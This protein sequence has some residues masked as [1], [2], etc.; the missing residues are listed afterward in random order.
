VAGN[1]S[2]S[3]KTFMVGNVFYNNL[4]DDNKDLLSYHPARDCY[5]GEVVNTV[6]DEWYKEN[7]S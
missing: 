5:H 4:N 7:C 6:M 2:Y 1:A 3:D